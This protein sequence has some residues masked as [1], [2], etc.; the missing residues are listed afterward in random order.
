MPQKP[1]QKIPAKTPAGDFK[2]VTEA[3]LK[4]NQLVT[5][6]EAEGDPFATL[7]AAGKAAGL[8]SRVIDGLIKRLRAQYGAV[9]EE[10]KNIH[11]GMLVDELT[12]KAWMALSYIDDY[13]LS[14]L[15]AKSAAIV[16]GILLEKRQLLRG[17]PTQ[18]ISHEERQGLDELARAITHES[19][20]RGLLIDL[21][22]TEVRILEPSQKRAT[23]PRSGG[24]NIQDRKKVAMNEEKDRIGEPR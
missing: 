19:E 12:K 5:I 15:D 1:P 2:P 21:E 23:R 24:K 3:E 6:L 22:P 14:Q 10:L 20:R 13:S 17:E 16:V 18:I 7:Q 11:S 8:P 9:T 4:D